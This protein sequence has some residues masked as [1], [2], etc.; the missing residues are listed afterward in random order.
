M[1]ATKKIPQKIKKR[2][3]ENSQSISLQK[4]F[5]NHKGRQIVIMGK[6]D[7]FISQ[8]NIIYIFPN[9]FESPY[10]F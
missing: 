1:I 9:I 2:N 5:T 4:N 3:K 10:R 7:A 8:D 6:S